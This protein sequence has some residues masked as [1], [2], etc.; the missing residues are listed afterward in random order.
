MAEPGGEAAMGEKGK[1]RT[2]EMGKFNSLCHF[3]LLLLFYCFIP[4]DFLLITKSGTQN[5]NVSKLI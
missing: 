3:Y 2:M 4:N 5:V 1:G